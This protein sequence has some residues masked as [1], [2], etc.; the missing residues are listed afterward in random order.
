MARVIIDLAK[1]YN[2]ASIKYSGEKYDYLHKRLVV[3]NHNCQKVFLPVDKQV[4]VF[5]VTLTGAALDFYYEI[6]AARAN[7]MTFEDAVRLIEDHFE[8]PEMKREYLSEWNATTLQVLI[9][10][11]PEKPKID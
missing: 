9:D 3:L 4:R 8:T 11:A 1:I 6:I 10:E 7:D 5:S 2:N